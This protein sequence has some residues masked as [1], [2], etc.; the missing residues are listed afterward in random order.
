MTG[1][2]GPSDPDAAA[3]RSA[4][5]A[6]ALAAVDERLRA[7]CAAAG[8]RRDEVTLI[9]VS[10][11]RPAA[12]IAALAALGVRDFGENRDQEA[13]GKARE[14]AGLDLAWH[15]VGQLQTNKCRSVAAYAGVVHSV[16][17][18]RLVGVLGS[19]AVRAGRKIDVLVQVSLDGDTRRGGVPA[20]A[21]AELAAAVAVAPALRLRGVMAIAP[22]AVEPARAFGQLDRVAADLRGLHPGAT[23]ISAGMSADL[24]AAVA[25]GATHVRLGTALFGVRPPFDR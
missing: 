2:A 15:F 21:V 6:A 22:L 25:A 20:P 23:W 3:G 8:R 24:E 1:S 11:T 7:A 19:E 17:R 10:K 9:A 4:A 13:A 5:L 12:D 14:L 16:D 18:L